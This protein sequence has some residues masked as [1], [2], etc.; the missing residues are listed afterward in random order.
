[1]QGLLRRGSDQLALWDV[2]LALLG[3]CHVHV[4]LFLCGACQVQPLGF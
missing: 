3:V 1:M 2:V 4:S